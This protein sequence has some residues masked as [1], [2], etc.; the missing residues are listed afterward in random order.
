MEENRYVAG[1]DIYDH[2]KSL[3][4]VCLFDRKKNEFILASERVC[5]IRLVIKLLPFFG[6][7]VL[8]EK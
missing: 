4:V 2:D 3:G 5:F 1:I 8:V 7:K 6:I